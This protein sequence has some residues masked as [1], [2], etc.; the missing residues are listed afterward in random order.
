M[1]S[2]DEQIFLNQNDEEYLKNYYLGQSV[3]DVI[4]GD[5]KMPPPLFN[6]R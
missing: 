3:N 6:F 2:F 4:D 5:L 1:L